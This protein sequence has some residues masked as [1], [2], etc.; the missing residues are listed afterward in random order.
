MKA[1]NYYKVMKYDIEGYITENYTEEELNEKMLDIE[2]FSEELNDNLWTADS[3][4]GNG[5]GSYTFCRAT[6][7]DYILSDSENVALLREALIEFCVDSDTIAEKFL[8]GEWEYFDVT[9]RCYLLGGV[10]TDVL[11]GFKI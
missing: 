9:I 5:S 8:W 11:E 4:T 7:R 10:I 1:Y 6:A 3:V 2:T